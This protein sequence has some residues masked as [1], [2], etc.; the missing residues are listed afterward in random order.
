VDRREWCYFTPN[1]YDLFSQTPGA[2]RGRLLMRLAEL[3]ERDIDEISA[4]EALNNGK[5]FAVS[6]S[7]DVAQSAA[8]LRYY[9]GWA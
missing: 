8:V 9:G 5:T 6:K 1:L 4:L 2:E 7:F 3:V